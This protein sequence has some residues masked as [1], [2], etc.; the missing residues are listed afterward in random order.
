M[1][2]W[3]ALALVALTLLTCAPDRPFSL[4]LVAGTL[5]PMARATGN[6]VASLRLVWNDD[7]GTRITNLAGTTVRTR[8]DIP[9]DRLEGRLEVRGHLLTPLADGGT[10]YSLARTIRVT[11]SAQS[12][13]L[14][15]FFAPIET[16]TPV[17]HALHGVR[18]GLAMAALGTRGALL[19]GGREGADGGLSTPAFELYDALTGDVCVDDCPTVPPDYAQRTAAF[20]VTLTDGRVVHGAG[21]DSSGQ[22][23]ADL[24]VTGTDGVTTRLSPTL[25]APLSEVAAARG[26]GNTVLLFGGR[27]SDGG[28]SDAVAQVFVDE[29]RLEVSQRLSRARAGAS[30][31]VTQNPQR[32]VV[33]GG[34]DGSNTPVLS[35]EV[36]DD[37]LMRSLA[38][39]PLKTPRVAPAVVR[40]PD[41]TLFIIGGGS[42]VPEAFTLSGELGAEVFEAAVPPGAL[43]VPPLAQAC[44]FEDGR[45]L[46]TGGDAVGQPF[47][48]AVF[49]PSERQ[50]NTLGGLWSA[51]SPP[52]KAHRRGALLTL[53]D[54]TALLAGGQSSTVERLVLP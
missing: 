37:Q 4:T 8:F 20:A 24:W 5:D 42:A 12:Q 22:P 17:A 1:N 30:V 38:T 45:V 48:A 33:I 23:R 14:T 47:S 26:P 32:W 34:T 9:S 10:L 27:S 2:A 53:P 7:A 6:P 29:N 54:D 50:G 28:V 15:A 51:L 44:G 35:V 3:R 11:P 36:F 46:V 43:A 13:T 16:F 25:P 21:L 41:E 52:T 18:E 19:V 49:T 31:G 40:L 39:S